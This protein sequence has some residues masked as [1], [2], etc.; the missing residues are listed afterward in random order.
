VHSPP[1]P[2]TR[3]ASWRVSPYPHPERT[4]ATG[5][6]W[7]AASV[8][9]A[10]R[11]PDSATGTS[12]YEILMMKRCG[13]TLCWCACTCL[14]VHVRVCVCMT[15]HVRVCVCMTLH[16]RVCVCMTLHV[17]VCVCMCLCEGVGWGYGRV[18]EW[19]QADRVCLWVYRR[20]ATMKFMPG[21]ALLL[22]HTYTVTCALLLLHTHARA[23]SA[24]FINAVVD[25]HT[26]HTYT[27]SLTHACTRRRP[28]CM[29]FRGA[30]LMQ[31]TRV[32]HGGQC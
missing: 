9:V 4:H 24:S 10:A 23:H 1:A 26:T 22:R 17:R 5:S 19:P 31:Q 7:A 8:I 29:C 28:G 14:C 21:Y 6:P 13:Y 11:V 15:L 2:L 25:R 20:A 16:V 30:L 12:D 32:T 27:H 18:G 3:T